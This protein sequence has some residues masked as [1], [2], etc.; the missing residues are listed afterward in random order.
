MG[1]DAARERAFQQ[2]VNTDQKRI[3]RIESTLSHSL[4]TFQ[5]AKAT[6]TNVKVPD[7]PFQYRFT[8]TADNYARSAGSLLLVR[9]HVMG[10]WSSDI[11]ESKEPRKYPV[12]FRGPEK[13]TDTYEITLPAGYEVDEL[14][15][16]VDADYSFG[17]YHSKTEAKGNV[18]TYT[19]TMEIR[20]LS[21]PVEKLEQLKSFYRVIV[22]DERNTA[23]LKPAGK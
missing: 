13:D 11:M 10:S 9:P 5:I 1:D 14:P 23:V 18:L 17:G 20:E 6:A 21:V 16:P 3:E 8:F 2:T 4:G 7:Q 15:P 22:G 12:E 19:R